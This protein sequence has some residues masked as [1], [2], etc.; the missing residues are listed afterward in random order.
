MEALFNVLLGIIAVFFVFLIIKQ[1]L[2]KKSREKMC[3][4]CLSV[5]LTWIFLL[6][7]YFFNV[8]NNIILI[9]LL[10]GQ[11]VVGFFYFIESKASQKFKIFRLPFLLTLTAIAYFLIT[12]EIN[13]KSLLLIIILWILFV[14]V[15]LYRN[16][17]HIK[18]FVK[19]LIECCKR[20]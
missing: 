2:P 18:G 12:K 13:L 4:I 11:S 8:F 1:L 15:Y 10:M 16:N 9:A 17:P 14:F 19:K 7:L 20:W 5:S 3:V 6:I